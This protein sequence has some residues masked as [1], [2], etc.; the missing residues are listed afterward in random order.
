[1]S[2]TILWIKLTNSNVTLGNEDTNYRCEEFGRRSPG[3]HKSGSCNVRTDAQLETK[4]KNILSM[5]FYKILLFY[6]NNV[7]ANKL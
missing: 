1:M 7:L 4:T 5:F 3:S 6:G 2:L